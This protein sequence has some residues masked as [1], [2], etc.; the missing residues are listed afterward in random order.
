MMKVRSFLLLVILGV[1]SS[2]CATTLGGRSQEITVDSDPPGATVGIDCGLKT[3]DAGLTPLKVRVSRRAEP[4]KVNVSKEGYEAAEVYLD[5]RFN[6]DTLGN[7]VFGGGALLHASED[8]DVYGAGDDLL[9]GIVVTGVGMA[10][11]GIS[12]AMWMRYPNVI[13]VQLVIRTGTGPDSTPSV[14]P[15]ESESGS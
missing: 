14:E 3:S 7:L 4:C 6:P 2:G 11:D 5:S 10:V 9:G 8:E 13:E 15:S 12:G 1:L